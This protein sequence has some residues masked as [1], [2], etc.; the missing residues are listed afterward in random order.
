MKWI[1]YFSINIVVGQDNVEEGDQEGGDGDSRGVE[2]VTVHL[3]KIELN[4]QKKAKDCRLN[5][6]FV[7]WI[8]W[9][10]VSFQIFYIFKTHYLLNFF[11]N[12]LI[13]T[14]IKPASGDRN[15]KSKFSAQNLFPK[16][17]FHTFSLLSFLMVKVYF[18]SNSRFF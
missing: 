12:F 18:W 10:R 2:Q 6:D 11:L 8:C 1:T 3:G 14:K 9:V 15:E 16:L 17:R 7:Y 4:T 13:K 5:I